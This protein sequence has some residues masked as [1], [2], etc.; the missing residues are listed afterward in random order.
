[1]HFIS[2]AI[3]AVAAFSL[4]SCGETRQ[5]SPAFFEKKTGLPLCSSAKIS[6]KTV[7]DHDFETDFVYSVN[8]NMDRKCEEQLISAISERL[9]VEC[10]SLDYC[11]FMDKNSWSYEIKRLNASEINFTLRA[12]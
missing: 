11:N 4:V 10:K 7:G 2:K 9:E 5:E 8:I 3:V 12:T 1:M 6:N